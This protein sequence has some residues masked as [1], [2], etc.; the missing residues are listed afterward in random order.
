MS[1]VFDDLKEDDYDLLYS[2]MFNYINIKVKDNIEKA[3]W[4][5]ALMWVKTQSFLNMIHQKYISINKTDDS[6]YY[7][8]LTEKLFNKFYNNETVSR[9]K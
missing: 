1:D 7:I 2:T 4:I 6:K 5:R 3:V 9:I 8:E